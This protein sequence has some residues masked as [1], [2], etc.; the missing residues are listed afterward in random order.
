MIGVFLDIKITFD[1]I[2]KMHA[3]VI[4]GN[5]LRWFRSYLTNISQFVSYDGILSITHAITCGV[6]HGSMIGPLLFIIH[7]NDI[8]NVSEL[9]FNVLY[10]DNTSVVIHGKIWLV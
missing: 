10:S 7:M 6:P 9:R 3:Y 4:R 1:I 8:C 2:D 5:I